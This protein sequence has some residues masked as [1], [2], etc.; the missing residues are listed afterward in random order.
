M[1]NVKLFK[2]AR[3]QPVGYWL[4]LEEPTGVVH[5]VIFVHLQMRVKCEDWRAFDLSSPPS[6]FECRSAQNEIIFG[7]Y[8]GHGQR[9]YQYKLSRLYMDGFKVEPLKRDK[10]S[11][12]TVGYAPY[13]WENMK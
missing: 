13:R 1:R 5:Q 12:V 8:G 4:C 2:P 10:C 7:Y 3:D 9:A 11:C 6:S